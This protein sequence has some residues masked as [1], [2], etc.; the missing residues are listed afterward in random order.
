MRNSCLA[1]SAILLWQECQEVKYQ[2]QLW[3]YHSIP[4][5]HMHPS[6][7]LCLTLS[8][9][10]QCLMNLWCVCVFLFQSY[11]EPVYFYIYT[12]F[13][14]QAVYVIAL[15]LTAWLLSGSWL[16]GT[17]TGVWYILNRW[18]ITVCSFWMDIVKNLLWLPLLPMLLINAAL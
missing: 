9:H 3:K 13:S 4:E 16:A 7:S 2:T 12:V 5:C 1:F 15:Y 18:V 10:L 8:V 14:L 17:L 6:L 11:L